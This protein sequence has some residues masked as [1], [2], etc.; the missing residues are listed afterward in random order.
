M[1]GLSGNEV[2]CLRLKGFTPGDIV[3]G[4]S[5]HSLGILGNIGAGLQGIFG[6]E[7][8]QVTNIISEGRHAAFSRLISEAQQHGAAG[9]TGVTNELR[10]LRGNIEFLSVASSLH[11]DEHAGEQLAFS[12]SSDGQELYCLLDCGYVP[13]KFVFG[14]VAYSIG[15]GGGLLGGLKS[16]ARGEIREFSDIFNATRHLALQRIVDEARAAGANAVLGIETRVMPF[17]GVHEMLMFG[18]AAFHPALPAQ[19]AAAPV[20]SDMTCQETWNMAKLGYA[21]IKLVLRTAIYSLGVVGGIKAAFQSMT[22]GEITDL[23]SLIYDAREHAISLLKQEA[24]SV[25]AD[26]VIGIHV[27]IHELGS[28]IEFM[29]VGTAVKRLPGVNTISPE[30]PPQAV[31]RDKSTWVTGIDILGEQLTV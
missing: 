8:T 28:L 7:V 20:T 9:L 11:R 18:T 17:Q 22:R 3:I 19:T 15:V 25:G 16:L 30:L 12:S 24:D 23:T 2:Y 26:D 31:I 14:N 1:T 29:A 5:V 21:P 10:H 4:N 6:G 13:R 27:H